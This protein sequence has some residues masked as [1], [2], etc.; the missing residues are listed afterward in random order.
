[1]GLGMA[2]EAPKPD[3]LTPA[4]GGAPPPQRRQSSFQ[5]E[6]GDPDISVEFVRKFSDN[7]SLSSSRYHSAQCQL[8]DSYVVDGTVL[9]CGASGEVV[10]ATCRL[11]GRRYALKR[12]S[13][14]SLS[15]EALSMLKREVEI[16]LTL[17]HPNIVRLHDV[18]DSE[19]ALALVMECC[20]GGELFDH[21]HRK[22]SYAECEAAHVTTQMLRAVSYLQSQNIAHR[23]LKLENFLY[24]DEDRDA[25]L[26]LIDFGFA[27]VWDH[28][29]PMK[30]A[31]GSMDYVSPDVL[32]GSGYTDACDMWSLG[33]IV[34]MLLAGHP[35]FYG[36]TRRDVAMKI[37]SGEPDWA[38]AAAKWQSVS[39]DGVDF[40]LR[41]LTKDPGRR[42]SAQQ[43][44]GLRWVSTP[45]FS[46][47]SEVG[48]EALR[49]LRR[50]AQSSRLRRA[51][52]QLL[53]QELDP[54]AEAHAR[55]L[56]TAF[57]RMD[58]DGSGRVPLEELRDAMRWCRASSGEDAG[59]GSFE[60]PTPPQ[61]PLAPYGAWGGI[62]R[63]LAPSRREC[64]H[65]VTP[66]TS[67][68]SLLDVDEG[69]PPASARTP[70]AGMREL[71]RA[72]DR[73]GTGQVS[74]SDFLAATMGSPGWRPREGALRRAFR[75]LD[76][77]GSGAVDA[78][79]LHATL[80]ETLDGAWP[81][82]LLSEA[83]L[84]GAEGM[85]YEAFVKLVE[86]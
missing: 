12:F 74:Y 44:L 79:D 54:R 27:K 86:G 66:S 61:S 38:S 34:F 85:S 84:G 41:L 43:A 49:S 1:M 50:Y 9:G 81:E 7:P 23:D 10:A 29:T 37:V 11:D 73:K 8:Q 72:L 19:D 47:G 55:E 16:Y 13:K 78:G 14:Q 3:S 31:C 59:F 17:D 35:P 82:D 70:P 2:I 69:A 57:L 5:R 77:D 15:P 24:E 71:C 52:L 64:K 42:P 48:S 58:R 56:R 33:V 65:C 80:G 28:M 53:A 60:L 25:H 51:V 83:G 6:L 21:L 62:R 40:V 30:A 32:S 68:S 39:R 18:Y 46:L 76:A 36:G 22:Q 67:A 4:P 75:R 20:N 26:K 45:K 63:L